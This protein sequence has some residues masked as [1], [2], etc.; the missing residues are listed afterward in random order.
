MSEVMGLF[1][2]QDDAPRTVRRRRRWPWLVAV[3][4]VLLLIVAAFF[5]GEWVARD[6]VT[7][8]VKQQ[9]VSRLDLAAD[10]QIDVDIADPSLLLDL[11]VGEVGRV[12]IS[13]D[14]VTIGDFTGNVSV[15]LHD[16]GIRAPFTLGSGEAT[17][18]LDADQL[19]AVLADATS[20]PIDG[21]T[22]AEP[23]V[24]TSTS[25]AVF[26]VAVPVVV[27]LTPSAADGHLVLSPVSLQVAGAEVT[28][29]GLRARLGSVA[30]PL[31]AG[32]RVCVAQY[33]PRGLTLSQVAAQGDRLVADFDI[34][35]ELLTDAGAREKGSCA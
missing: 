19:R 12:R 13:A 25:L 15:T 31:L 6:L 7:K 3:L 32:Y 4:V 2:D 23:A 27:A 29:D 28:A 16:L 8:A 24:S 14:D 34:A 5:A 10:Q 26:G 22:I 17:V 1:D 20:V 21:V 9:L 11:A 35:G 18:S 33:L 30:D